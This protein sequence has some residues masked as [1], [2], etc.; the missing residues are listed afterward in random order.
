[1]IIGGGG[2]EHALAWK[3]RQSPLVSKVF[4][5]PGNGGT[6]AIAENIQMD[7]NDLG[8]MAD[9]AAEHHIDLTVVEQDGFLAKGMVDF[10]KER[11]LAIYGPT[12]AA[13][14]LEWSKSYA[15]EFMKRYDIPTAKFETFTDPA[16]AKQYLKEI[17]APVVVKADGLAAGKGVIVA[18]DLD[19]ALQ[20]VDQIMTGR[21]FG[22][23]GTV[24]VIEEFL[25]GEEVSLFA[26][27]D[28]HSA[29]PLISAQDHKRIGEGDT[30]LNTGGMGAYAPTLV[31]TKELTERVIREILNPTIRGMQAEGSPF[32]GTLYLG[33]MLTQTGPKVI[34][35]NAR[36][37]DPE[38]QVVLPLLDSDLAQIYLDAVAGKLNPDTVRW[39][40]DMRAV[41]VV[42]ASAGYPGQFA[43]GKPVSGLEQIQ[44]SIVFHAG[45]RLNEAGTLVTSGGRVLNLVHLGQT[46]QKAVTGA[47]QDL[48]K[49]RFDGIYYRNDIA[50]REL[51]RHI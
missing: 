17:G 22:D 37:G 29:V 25:T 2:R 42:A 21:V 8:A 48:A 20:A 15:K 49:V 19:T 1:M 18:T 5:C 44:D 40:K 39:K 13:A 12:K 46:I 35:Y 41:C 36:F 24:V 4:C 31:L 43:S 33:L 11:G 47:Y 38:T 30:G 10:F 23:S 32:T 3:L 7:P 34:E 16:A 28:G 9:F 6:T 45:T 27:C 26:F 51:K 14:K 50:W